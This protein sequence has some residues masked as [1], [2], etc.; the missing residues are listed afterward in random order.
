MDTLR[1]ALV[2]LKVGTVVFGGGMSMIPLMEQDVVNRYHWL[3]PQEFM[4]AVA[5]GQM[6]PGP[7]LV[8]V[9]FIGYKIGGPFSATVATFCI[10]LPSCLLTILVTHQLVRLRHNVYVR[11]F[12]GGVKPAVVGLLLSAGVHFGRSALGPRSLAPLGKLDFTFRWLVPDRLEW[13]PTLTFDLAALILALTALL[14]LLGSK[15]IAEAK[16]LPAWLS[17]VLRPRICRQLHKID[18]VHVIVAAGL[19]G[20]WVYR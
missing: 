6:T 20:W 11:G 3:T 13:E 17:K 14:V 5:L 12:L 16:D 10:F 9:T 7:L 15:R 2:C 8:S 4:D 18:A 19:I 1:L